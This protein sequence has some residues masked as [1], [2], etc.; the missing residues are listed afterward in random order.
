MEFDGLQI[1]SD[2]VNP[3][4]APA[5]P[6]KK[7]EEQVDSLD[8]VVEGVNG[9]NELLQ[10]IKTFKKAA[11]DHVVYGVYNNMDK[12]FGQRVNDF[13]IDHSKIRLKEK[14]YFFHMLAVMVDAGIPVVSA[15]K[16]LASRGENIRFKRVLNTVAYNCE[17]GANLADSMSRF[18][19]VFDELEIGIVRSGEATGKLHQMLFKLSGMLDKKHDLN[20]KLWGAA[21]YPI[22]VL[23]VLLLVAIGMLVFVFPTLLNLLSE[24]GIDKATLPTAT[25]ILMALQT[26][27]VGYWWLIVLTLFGLYG[28]FNVYVSSDYGA[29]RWDYVKLKIPLIGGILRKLFVLRFVGMLGILIEAGLPVIKA[30][31]ITG[32]ALSNRIYKLKTQEIIN[33][34]KAGGKISDN[35]RDSEFLFPMEVVQMVNVGESSANLA[36]IS[37]KI[38]DQ[39]QREVDNSLKKISSLFEPI[40]ILVVG[41]FVALL[42]LAIMAPI[43]NLS[44][45]VGF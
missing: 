17:Q 10:Q 19:E 9:G 45:N 7:V 35:L 2:K 26:A 25:K 36:K 18:E 32:G 15:V 33:G 44:S 5:E 22:A 13:F 38:S 43:F 23:C 20:M 27:V 1:K 14:S 8:Y 39:Y 24:G 29:T 4:P 3:A 12:G 21:V 40:M 41:V 11:E 42:A 28:V 16:S 37:E 30:L 31:K 6:A 34:V